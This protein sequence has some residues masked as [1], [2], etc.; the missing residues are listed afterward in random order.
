[1]NK[2][3]IANLF[4]L[5]QTHQKIVCL[6]ASSFLLAKILDQH[7][8]IILVG[9]S[10]AMTVY[11][12]NNTQQVSLSTMIEHGKA[13]VNATKSAMVVVD[14]PFGSYEN[15][16]HQALASAR[17]VILKTNCDA[18]KI[19]TSP[20]L[21]STVE[22]L[23]ANKIN[24]MAHIGL[25][26]QHF[27]DPK[28]FR[29]K[30]RNEKDAEQIFE[31]ALALEKAG[32]FA[33][34]IEAVPEKLASKISKQLS[35][36]TIGIGASLDCDGQVLVTDD[37]LGMNQDLSLKFVHKYQNL[38]QL[39]NQAVEEFSNDVRNKKFPFEDNLLKK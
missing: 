3:N 11:G 1:M 14:L 39:I 22:F 33:I 16:H 19:E 37:L 29:Y 30:G 7:C 17:E 15:C 32:A 27:S 28:D 20:Q 10:L 21:I 12:H 2:K 5:K 18:I 8:D 36:P 26:P 35:I 34:V 13:V 31:N 9:D 38:Y 24:V 4:A 25:M 23:V 6:T